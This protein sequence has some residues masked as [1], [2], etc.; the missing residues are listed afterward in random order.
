MPEARDSTKGREWGRRK[1]KRLEVWTTLPARS[2]EQG[3]RSQEPGE[4][5]QTVPKAAKEKRAG[6]KNRK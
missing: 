6:I 3:A 1:G 5:Q 2:Q 4:I